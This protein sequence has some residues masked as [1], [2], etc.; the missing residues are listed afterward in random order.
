LIFLKGV[1][2]MEVWKPLRD[3]PSY[4]GS[5][6]GRVMNVRTQHILKSTLN[7]KGKPQLTL[8]KN[9]Q[10]YTVRID[11]LIAETFLGEHPGMDV[12]HRDLDLT[13]NRVDNLYW[14]T[15]SETVADAFI[16][17]TKTPSRQYAVR[18]VETGEIYESIR[19]CERATGCSQSEICKYLAG[20]RSH[21]KGYHFELV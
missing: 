11:R 20:R 1:I 7:T 13:N 15:R 12:R 19:A 6:E 18:V 8:R 17:G 9:N 3:F 14:S 4:N 2:K 21:V 10:P 5:S 16:R